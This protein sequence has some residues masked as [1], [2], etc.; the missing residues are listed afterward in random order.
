MKCN[1]HYFVQKRTSIQ[2]NKK[3]TLQIIPYDFN[4]GVLENNK[5]FEGYIHQFIAA[6]ENKEREKTKEELV[7]MEPLSINYL[8]ACL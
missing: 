7:E 8:Y 4:K 5:Q 2:N 6:K 1:L 3:E